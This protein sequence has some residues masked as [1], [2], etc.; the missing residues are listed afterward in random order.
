MS[1]ERRYSA[2][3]RPALILAALLLLGSPNCDL[4]EDVRPRTMFGEGVEKGPGESLDLYLNVGLLTSR[5]E[6]LY[7]REQLDQ[8]LERAGQEIHADYPELRFHFIVDQPQDTEFITAR[9]VRRNRLPIE[10]PYPLR[11]SIEDKE[12]YLHQIQLEPVLLIGAE[13]PASVASGSLPLISAKP[14]SAV[15]GA[16]ALRSEWLSSS[17]LDSR[18]PEIEEYRFLTFWQSYAYSQIHYDVIL[19]DTRIL[20]DDPHSLR[21]NPFRVSSSYL[22]PAPG[23]AALDRVAVIVSIHPPGEEGANNTDSIRAGLEKLV[24]L[25]KTGDNASMRQKRYELLRSLHLFHQEGKKRGC[26]SWNDSSPSYRDAFISLDPLI[27]ELLMENLRNM[28]RLCS[29]HNN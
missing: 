13:F 26:R 14:I 6:K 22:L 21:N 7:A 4:L 24:F 3:A 23:R 10:S 29:T 25:G 19:V 12:S 8:W 5:S 18:D 20:P 17:G 9:A 16:E 11:L 27:V 15:P 2:N 1:S 28:D